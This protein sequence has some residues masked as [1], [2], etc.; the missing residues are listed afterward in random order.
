MLKTETITIFNRVPARRG[1]YTWK[2]TVIKG[3]H[4]DHSIDHQ[5]KRYGKETNNKITISMPLQGYTLPKEWDK[6]KEGFTLH[7]NVDL[8]AI[9]EWTGVSEFQLDDLNEMAKEYD[10]VF[11]VHQVSRFRLIPHL[12]V[13][14]G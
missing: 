13:A 8:I 3:V 4:I 12:E 7:E 14:C 11:T 9:G 6:T 10:D 5:M 2:T 1:P